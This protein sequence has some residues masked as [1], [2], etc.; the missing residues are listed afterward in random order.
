MKVKV[1]SVDA[2]SEQLQQAMNNGNKWM[3]YRSDSFPGAQIDFFKSIQDVKKFF[4]LQFDGWQFHKWREI[5]P[6]VASLAAIRAGFSSLKPND[7]TYWIKPGPEAALSSLILSIPVAELNADVLVHTLGKMGAGDVEADRL[8]RM[9]QK[10]NAAFSIGLMQMMGDDKIKL[11]FQ[12]GKTEDEWY[13][14]SG[15][16]A[17]LLAKMP[18]EHTV[19]EGVD[20]RALEEKMQK[21]DWYY[22]SAESD[23]QVAGQYKEIQN[24]EEAIYTLSGDEKGKK[25]ATELWNNYVPIYALTKPQFIREYEEQSDLYQKGKFVDDISIKDA[26]E[27][28]RRAKQ[29]KINH[30]FERVDDNDGSHFSSSEILAREQPDDPTME[31]TQHQKEEVIAIFFRERKPGEIKAYLD[32]QLKAGNNWLAY[33]A[34]ADVLTTDDLHGFK[35]RHESEE[36]CRKHSEEGDFHFLKTADFVVEHLDEW[37]KLKSDIPG[38]LRLAEEKMQKADWYYDYSDDFRVWQK[39]DR[40]ISEIT[41]L[42]QLAATEGESNAADRLWEKY[43]PE[44]SVVKPEFLTNKIKVMTEKE[45]KFIEDQFKSIGALKAMTPE[46]WEQMKQGVQKIEHPHQEKYEG[47]GIAKAKFYLNKGDGNNYFLNKW[48]MEAIREGQSNG[49]KQTF[50]NNHLPSYKDSEKYDP[51]KHYTTFT[52]KSSFN[53]LMGDRPVHNLYRNDNKEQYQQWD[54]LKIKK[55]EAGEITTEAKRYHENY[56]FDHEKVLSGYN[57]RELAKQDHK[58]RLIQSHERGNMQLATFVNNEGRDVKLY[59]VPNISLGALNIY[60]KDRKPVSIDAQIENGYVQKE[61]GEK[62]KEKLQ[63]LKLK[64]GDDTVQKQNVTHKNEQKEKQDTPKQEKEG[65][66]VRNEN[67]EKHKQKESVHGERKNTQRN[68]HKHGLQ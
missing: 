6:L 12:F 29:H 9:M 52:F 53:Y 20:V 35:T 42:L 49:V 60:D 8:E 31:S 14:L 39:G 33:A 46:L 16:R 7:D 5:R 50:H 38:L 21:A 68:R 18:I 24:I 23:K 62:L 1:E 10:D 40:Q 27:A 2:L 45:S 26:C 3:V 57:I 51:A 44:H 55:G 34:S 13:S 47:D 32:H 66:K 59:T 25:I 48:D 64:N 63:E 61:F 11:Q 22:A 28:L 30:S 15:Y 37:L 17:T 58:D 56:P 65:E 43:V 41:R 19:I 36:F 67:K 4:E 54:V